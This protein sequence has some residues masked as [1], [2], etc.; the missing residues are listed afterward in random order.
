LD[1]TKVKEVWLEYEQTLREAGRMDDELVNLVGFDMSAEEA[2]ELL[3]FA[4]DHQAGPGRD[5]FLRHMIAI[6]QVYGRRA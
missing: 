4:K 6:S 5:K 1:I 3:E 2:E